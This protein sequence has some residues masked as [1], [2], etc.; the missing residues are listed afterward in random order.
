MNPGNSKPGR[1]RVGLA[2]RLIGLA[3]AGAG[4][5]VAWVRRNRSRRAIKEYG[6][7][8]PD[9]YRQRYPEAAGAGIDPLEHYLRHGAAEGKNPNPEFETA[10][11]LATYPDVAACGL[12]P[13]AHYA[14]FGMGENRFYAPPDAFL[15]AE[16]PK[17]PPW[18][19]AP[20][21]KSWP[22]IAVQA[23]LYY[24]DLV[25]E[26][27]T[28]ALAV[29]GEAHILASVVSNEAK[30]AAQAWAARNGFKRLDLRLMPNRGRDVSGFTTAFGPDLLDRFDLFCHIHTK[31]SPHIGSEALGA[32]WRHHDIGALL[33]TPK[34]AQSIVNQFAARPGLG[35]AFG[36]PNPTVTYWAYTWLDNGE[37]ARKLADV[38]GVPLPPYGYLDFPA[39]TMF[40]GRPA[41]LKQLLDGRIKTE[42]FAEEADQMGG[43]FAHAIER[44]LG[45]LCQANSYQYM[46]VDAVS[47]EE[48][49]DYC[50]KNFWQYGQAATYQRL[51]RS[52]DL[53]RVVSFD[54]VDTLLTPVAGD[55]Q[56][57]PEN[58][59][60]LRAMVE[61]F[62]RQRAQMGTGKDTLLER[63]LPRP[64][65]VE[66]LRYAL[67][68]GKRVILTADDEVDKPCLDRLLAECEI[69][70][71]ARIY[72]PADAGMMKDTKVFWDWLVEEE[73]IKR[74]E[75]LHVGDNET[76]D[77]LFTLFARIARFHVLSA[78]N[79]LALSPLAS[80]LPGPV[81]RAI[82]GPAPLWPAFAKL[83]EDPFGGR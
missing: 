47:G 16:P 76:S 74:S 58:E 24:P 67:K 4:P 17:P 48:Y 66:A 36:S 23:H 37:P 56:E 73:K 26:V 30:E 28:A 31:K 34:R 60:D 61:R 44:A 32:A 25:D 39:G 81:R 13:L 22:R 11:Y 15:W 2:G 43:T 83:F 71:Y 79:M 18:P 52:I 6:L 21:A 77:I 1:E 68:R 54:I 75:L 7:F 65:V 72:T 59:A 19:A 8:D 29:P 33:G 42:M 78:K 10:W 38:L 64:R 45:L 5:L 12:N 41:A 49:P 50:S 20:K 62:A 3:R 9:W 14:L 82:G 51:L 27:L 80:G 63:A 35:L 55:S 70:G 46:Q 53:K 69:T 57:I 40:W